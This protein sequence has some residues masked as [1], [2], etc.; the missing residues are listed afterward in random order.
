MK[1]DQ[2]HSHN[3]F[4]VSGAVKAIYSFLFPALIVFVVIVLYQSQCPDRAFI[5]S[6][7]LIQMF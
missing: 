1:S 4:S 5:N 2:K 7:D 3:F 6:Q